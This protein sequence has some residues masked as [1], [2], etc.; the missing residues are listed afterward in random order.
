[1]EFEASSSEIAYETPTGGHRTW[2]W[3]LRVAAGM[4]TLLVV[5][6]AWN[7]A[8]QDARVGYPE[9]EH[10]GRAASIAC[11]LPGANVT[12]IRRENGGYL[13]ECSYA[14]FGWPKRYGV[15]KCVAGA[16]EWNGDPSEGP[17]LACD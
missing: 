2:A 4:V 15:M 1:M 6:F 12:S 11:P 14:P 9:P 10:A 13:V 3:P 17:A 16:W 8:V 7:V 5:L